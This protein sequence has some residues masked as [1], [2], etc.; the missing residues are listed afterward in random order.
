MNSGKH[1][2]KPPP[3]TP[4]RGVEQGVSSF[5]LKSKGLDSFDFLMGLNTNR[6]DRNYIR[7]DLNS[8]LIGLIDLKDTVS[9][10]NADQLT[11]YVSDPALESNSPKLFGFDD[12]A[13]V[14]ND[15][16]E[17]G[18]D[19]YDKYGCSLQLFWKFHIERFDPGF[20]LSTNP[21]SRHV[22]CRPSPGYFV[23]VRRDIQDKGSAGRLSKQKGVS[24]R[25]RLPCLL[26]FEDTSTGEPVITVECTN[27]SLKSDVLIPRAVRN[28]ILTKTTLKEVDPANDSSSSEDT[29]V[30]REKLISKSVE[31]NALLSSI[32]PSFWPPALGTRFNTTNYETTILDESFSI[33]SIPQVRDRLLPLSDNERP[34]ERIRKRHIYFHR[35]F[36][37]FNSQY[38]DI[39]LALV[40]AFLRPCEPRKKKRLLRN[41]HLLSSSS[42]LNGDRRSWAEFPSWGWTELK[43]ELKELVHSR[44]WH[45]CNF[46]LVLP[47]IK[48]YTHIGDGLHFDETPADDEPHY[49]HKYGWLTIYDQKIFENDGIF[50]TVVA[51]T[52]AASYRAWIL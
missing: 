16:A 20:Y 36:G 38:S 22:L 35:E 37:G 39:S 33:G 26:V 17:N 8:N 45:N 23:K 5:R 18:D 40:V 19:H 49:V 29:C 10:Y 7:K 11:D 52:V 12:S 2:R 41:L 46:Q 32:S 21:T 30:E 34:L 47:N 43:D 15:K 4:D 6:V 51:L 28:G 3:A 9:E 50:D 48:P 31:T 14:A 1:S 13:K 24:N 42:A 25:P 27:S 44:E